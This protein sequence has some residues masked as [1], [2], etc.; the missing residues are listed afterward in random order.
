MPNSVVTIAVRGA[1]RSAT[2]SPAPS[3]WCCH[4]R[5]RWAA[6]AA[7]VGIGATEF[8]KESGRSELSLACEAVAAA[9]EDAGLAAARGRRHGHVHRWRTTP[10]SRSPATSASGRCATSAASTTAAARRAARWRSAAMAVATGAADVVG[11]LPR[12]QRAQ[13]T[14]VRSRCAGPAERG[15]AERAAYSWT[16]PRSGCSRRRAGWRWWLAGTCTTTA[17][18]AR[19]S[20]GSR[21]P[22]ASTPRRTRR[23]GSTSSRSRSRSTRRA[24]G[25]SSRSTSS[26]A[27]RRPTARQALVVTTAERAR[28]LRQPPAIVAAAAQGAGADQWNDDEFYRDD[29][30][31]LPEMERRRRRAV[32]VERARARPTSRPRS[33]TTTSRRTC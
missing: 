11:V 4:E 16:Q 33:C 13:R 6:K 27:A 10:R 3:R 24:A 8:S 18:R 1:N 31:Q 17:R 15:H 12:V 14:P 5:R 2:T 29:I 28:D 30:A 21:W 20:D 19:T 22:T 9:I 7:I 25:S 26:T 32:G 23:R